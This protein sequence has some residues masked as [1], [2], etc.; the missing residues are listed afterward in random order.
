M[1]ETDVAVNMQSKS[2]AVP[3]Q[4]SKLPKSLLGSN[5]VKVMS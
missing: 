3:V 2:F 4:P 1:I 5:T